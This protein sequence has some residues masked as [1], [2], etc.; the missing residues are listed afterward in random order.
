MNQHLR[1]SLW[2]AAALAALPAPAAA[3]VDPC[4]AIAQIVAASRE[5]PPFDSIRRAF[6]RGEAVIPGLG[7]SCGV[8]A[9][10]ITCGH[11]AM[12]GAGRDDWPD[13]IQCPGLTAV[14]SRGGTPRWSTTGWP[15]NDWTRVYIGGGLR[16]ELGVG[17]SACRG[18]FNSR[19]V[20]TFDRP[21]RRD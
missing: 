1:R 9:Q 2:T 5:M 8:S 17:C 20:A 19:F 4:P 12:T 6:R 11:L 13:P 10:G 15:R 7:S 14:E 16:F 21:T 3:A 18:P